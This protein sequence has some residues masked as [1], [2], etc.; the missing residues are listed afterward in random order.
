MDTQQYKCYSSAEEGAQPVKGAAVKGRDD[1]YGIIK[2]YKEDGVWL[3]DAESLLN[4]FEQEREEEIQQRVEERLR[5]KE[6]EVWKQVPASSGGQHDE[7]ED[8]NG[9]RPSDKWNW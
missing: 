9:V 1:W 6:E 7:E 4:Y 3:N 5:A 8:E 2:I